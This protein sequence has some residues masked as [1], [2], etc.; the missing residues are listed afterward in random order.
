[1]LRQHL[2]SALSPAFSASEGLEGCALLAAGRCP[3]LLRGCW[4]EAAPGLQGRP[5]H[6]VVNMGTSAG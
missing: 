3:P 1:M 5:V 2:P 6:S 4:C